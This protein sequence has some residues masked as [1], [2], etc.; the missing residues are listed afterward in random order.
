MKNYLQK[1]KNAEFI[2]LTKENKYLPLTPLE[3]IS[4]WE[5]LQVQISNHPVNVQEVF[6]SRKVEDIYSLV[7]ESIRSD[8]K[9]LTIADLM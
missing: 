8:L 5:I 3:E 4:V 6:A 9:D 7:R 1:L 2:S